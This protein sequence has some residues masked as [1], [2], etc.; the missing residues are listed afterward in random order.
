[1]TPRR[2]F[3]FLMQGVLGW[4]AFWIAGLP[5]YFQQYSPELM[6]VGCTLLSVAFSL[7][8]LVSLQRIKPQFRMNNAFWISF[9]F[10]VPLAILDWLYCSVYLGHGAEYLV[11][12]WYLTVFYGSLWLTFMPT[13]WLLARNQN[14]Q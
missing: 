6:G 3:L 2:H 4:V 9:Y 10:T 7:G 12:Y 5:S 13:A 11:R 1:M 8:A 14:S